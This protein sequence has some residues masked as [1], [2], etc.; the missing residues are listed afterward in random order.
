M[1]PKSPKPTPSV[2]AKRA[3][4]PRDERA[5]RREDT[6]DSDDDDDDA[7]ETEDEESEDLRL[8]GVDNLST[9]ELRKLKD[10]MDI[11]S[12]L[13]PDAISA[14]N[15]RPLQTVT[16]VELLDHGDEVSHISTLI[17]RH[18]SPSLDRKTAAIYRGSK[19]LY[20]EPLEFWSRIL[21]G[22]RP[23]RPEL[24]P[25]VAQYNHS[26]LVD[27]RPVKAT[28][29]VET[30]LK[31]KPR[32]QAQ[33][34]LL[35]KILDKPM[36]AL[37]R[38]IIPALDYVNMP[39]L[40]K[41]YDDDFPEEISRALN[42]SNTL[43]RGFAMHTLALHSDLMHRRRILA[44]TALGASKQE[45]EGAKNVLDS[46]DR[47][48]LKTW[49]EEKKER[50]ILAGSLKRKAPEGGRRRK[51]GGRGNNRNRYR[52][53]EDDSSPQKSRGEGSGGE[54]ADKSAE[55]GSKD[56]SNKSKSTPGKKSFQRGK[57]K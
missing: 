43:L 17:D 20:D 22:I 45:A 51:G 30:A 34:D 2:V 9:A 1:A 21:S 49:A 27:L 32:D 8:H 19:D 3:I 29:D 5:R 4:T 14:L 54:N 50:I 41:D 55:K 13:T 26:A 25:S 16:Q 18:I 28:G 40:T 24:L 53:R 15:S 6:R 10:G 33:D 52:N 31:A 36:R 57:G 11:L 35:F 42:A 47:A 44:K 56:G 46:W 23:E 39:D 48:K 7:D 12:K 37:H 38:L